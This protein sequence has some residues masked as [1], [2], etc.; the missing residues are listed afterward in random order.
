MLTSNSSTEFNLINNYIFNNKEYIKSNRLR[1]NDYFVHYQHDQGIEDHFSA[2][3][4]DKTPASS[5]RYGDLTGYGDLTENWL[6]LKPSQKESILNQVQSLASHT[7][8]NYNRASCSSFSG[9]NSSA[10]RQHKP[11]LDNSIIIKQYRSGTK[12]LQDVLKCTVS[13]ITK[14]TANYQDA[15]RLLNN[16]TDAGIPPDVIIYNTVIS[17]CEKGGKAEEALEIF[18]AIPVGIKPD[19][20][21]YSAVISACEKG[22]KT[23]EALEIFNKMPDAGIP[24]NKITYSAVISACKKGGKAEE[25]LEIFNKMLDAG[26]KPSVITYSAVISACEKGGKAEE[27]LEIFKATPVG[28]TPD[29]I[30]YNAVISACEKGGKAEEALEIFNKMPDAGITPNVITYSAIISACEKGGKTEKAL[31]IFNKIK[32]LD[33]AIKPNVITYNAII[34]ACE[35]GGKA[36]KALEI[37]N[38]MPDAGITPDEIT[39]NAV[40]SACE[41]GGKTEKALE[42]FA[43]MYI[44]GLIQELNNNTLNLH[45]NSFYTY[46]MK[47][48]DGMSGIHPSVAKVAIQFFMNQNKIPH[49]TVITGFN[50]GRALKD[51]ILESFKDRVK[52]LPDNLGRLTIYGE[53]V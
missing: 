3:I 42:I 29:V 30:I 21:T 14:P 7:L 47:G 5:L 39:Y 1:Y 20:I 27:A 32:M 16:L 17:A 26:I 41:K 38:K 40:I 36:E 13:L 50:S 25:A 43:K 9:Q 37:F 10:S 11:V 19:V 35:K 4:K 18:K 6:Q 51:S 49:I 8:S 24:P 2:Y 34:S 53:L 22:G 44:E 28:I 48:G 45:R 12:N 23:E 52:E 33:A 15:I 31:E 46:P